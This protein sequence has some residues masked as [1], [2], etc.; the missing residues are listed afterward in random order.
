MEKQFTEEGFKAETHGG[1][2][3][4]MEVIDEK[5]AVLEKVKQLLMENNIQFSLSCCY[6]T[7]FIDEQGDIYCR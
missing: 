3:T 5:N 4:P 6:A 2:H 1:K 7:R